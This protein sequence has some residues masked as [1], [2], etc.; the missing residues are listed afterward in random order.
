MTKPVESL[1]SIS[2]FGFALRL[3]TLLKN[4]KKG[5]T[6]LVVITLACQELKS[7]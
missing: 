5:K 1:F 3:E 7:V 2:H 6:P 4:E